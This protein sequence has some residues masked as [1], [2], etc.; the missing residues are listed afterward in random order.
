VIEPLLQAERLLVH[1][2]V[3]QAEELFR[4]TL[5]ADPRNSI[6]VVGLAR[7]ALE[8]G[9]DHEAYRQACAAL[10]LDPQNVAALRLEARLSEVLGARGEPV[11][12][13]PWLAGEPGPLTARPAVDQ[14]VAAEQS[15][16]ASASEPVMLTRNPSMADHRRMDAARAP[17]PPA[18]ATVSRPAR[19]RPKSRLRRLLG[20]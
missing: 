16:G 10:E 18:G 5:Q 17:Q 13:P 15:P 6:A 20:L 4:R 14:P 1:G 2:Q 9:N 11:E 7:V 3:D 19:R 8:R 12:R